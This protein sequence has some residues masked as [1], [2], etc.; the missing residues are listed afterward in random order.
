[1]LRCPARHPLAPRSRSSPWH[2]P[3][4]DRTERFSNRDIL[5]A[6]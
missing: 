3:R 6:E 4:E 1:M 5:K 2:D